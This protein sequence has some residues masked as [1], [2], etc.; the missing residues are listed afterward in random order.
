MSK[1]KVDND[2]NEI[3]LSSFTTQMTLNNS[4]K[5]QLTRIYQR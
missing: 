4:W 2:Y 5:K 3:V 1:K